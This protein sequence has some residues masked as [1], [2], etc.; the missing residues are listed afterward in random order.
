[1]AQDR[2]DRASAAPPDPPENGP[3]RVDLA[4][5]LEDLGSAI[6][7]KL[8]NPLAGMMLSSLRLKKRLEEMPGEEK[9]VRLAGQ[10]GSAIEKLSGEVDALVRK[11]AAPP[12]ECSAVDLDAV[13]DSVAPLPRPGTGAGE[14]AVRRMRA[15]VLPPVVADPGLLRRALSNLLAHAL[16]AA[17]A[18][19]SLR[20]E[21]AV[22]G[23]GSAAVL[24][25][26]PAA[27][28][29]LPPGPADEDLM[30]LLGAGGPA[31][32]A[33]VARRI[34]DLHGARLAIREE[35]GRRFAVV[36]FPRAEAGDPPR[37]LPPPEGGDV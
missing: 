32:R 37:G 20:V 10:L 34:L 24:I 18:G 15:P 2:D 16:G 31:L 36:T 3:D 27:A 11:L 25:E 8:K 29:P 1:M 9:A 33:A 21:T 23:K 13:L 14:P 28:P 30:P 4:L 22:S 17:A 19:E 5:A 7:H 35:G 12:L 6:A 26:L